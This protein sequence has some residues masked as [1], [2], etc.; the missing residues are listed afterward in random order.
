MPLMHLAELPSRASKC[1][2]PKG[3]RGPC[4]ATVCVP[5]A[6]GEASCDAGPGASF[7]ETG[8]PAS[9]SDSG[10]RPLDLRS[11]GARSSS[12]NQTGACVVLTSRRHWGALPGAPGL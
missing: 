5:A 4:R 2:F 6:G 8:V 3:S 7:L 11:V 12:L 1:Y 10:A 9:F